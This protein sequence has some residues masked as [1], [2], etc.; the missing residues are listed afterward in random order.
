MSLLN[1]L[2]DQCRQAIP[3][4]PVLDVLSPMYCPGSPIYAAMFLRSCPLFPVLAFLS[5]LSFTSLPGCPVLAVLFWLPC[6]GCPASAFLLKLSCP[7]VLSPTLL[8]AYPVRTLVFLSYFSTRLFC[9][10]C[11]VP[12]VLFWLSCPGC[13]IPGC[14][15]SALS[16][17]GCVVLA[18]L[19]WLSCSCYPGLY[20][21]GCAERALKFYFH[22]GIIS[23]FYAATTYP[24][25]GQIPIRLRITQLYAAP[26]P[27]CINLTQFPLQGLS[28]MKLLHRPCRE[29]VK[30][31]IIFKY[32]G[33]N[34]NSS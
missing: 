31:H 30:M 21:S 26:G 17:T 33:L 25:M 3:N 23:L 14:P 19:Y 28:S 2:A 6:S 4:C 1:W 11:P 5:R 13:P 12:A 27:S 7:S 29:P 16:Y 18:V 22:H 34:E 20:F 8:S 15:V 9:P 10:G 24:E 32:F